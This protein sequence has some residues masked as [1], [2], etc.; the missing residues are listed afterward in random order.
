MSKQDHRHPWTNAADM[1]RRFRG[2]PS[3]SRAQAIREIRAWAESA[4]DIPDDEIAFVL[5][6]WLQGHR[7]SPPPGLMSDIEADDSRD[8]ERILRSF[9]A[10]LVNGRDGTL[11]SYLQRCLGNWTVNRIRVLAE[12]LE[13]AVSLHSNLTTK[14]KAALIRR[15]MCR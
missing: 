13:D 5:S 14:E 10:W 4:G 6:R 11:A 9:N 12:K 8:A 7:F 15:C 3:M 1:W 2:E